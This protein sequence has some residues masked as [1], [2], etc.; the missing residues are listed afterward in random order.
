MQLFQTLKDYWTNITTENQQPLETAFK[1]KVM[2]LNK[3]KKL[4]TDQQLEILRNELFDLAI[5][6]DTSDK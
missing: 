6:E 1:S 3:T 4:S 5:N 2:Q